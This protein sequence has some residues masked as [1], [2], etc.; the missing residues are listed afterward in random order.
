[1]NKQELVDAI[2]N[3][4][5][6]SNSEIENFLEAFTDVVTKELQNDGKVS[7]LGFGGFETSKR[8]ARV[9]RNPQTGAEIK[10]KAAVVPKFKAGKKLKDAVN[11]SN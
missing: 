5:S 2:A 9:G 3:R 11:Q 8:A 6:A 10:I 7:I 4:V 1:M